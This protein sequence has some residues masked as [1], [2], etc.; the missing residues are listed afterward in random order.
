MIV[1]Y[2]REGFVKEVHRYSEENVV[3]WR[4][5]PH[6]QF[7]RVKGYFELEGRMVTL[8][9]RIFAGFLADGWNPFKQLVCLYVLDRGA[10][11]KQDIISYIIEV[12][13]YLKD[14]KH[15][16]WWLSELIEY[17][18]SQGWINYRHGYYVIGDRRMPIGHSRIAIKEG[19]NPILYEIMNS[20]KIK[21]SKADLSDYIIGHLSWVEYDP[22]IDMHAEEVLHKESH[23]R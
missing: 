15:N 12:K 10:A 18:R 4:A 19:Y 6:P 14:T 7:H 3:R 11:S 8:E 22:I 1:K 23:G 13:K 5:K 9:P 17:L 21:G 16:R 20:L 2:T